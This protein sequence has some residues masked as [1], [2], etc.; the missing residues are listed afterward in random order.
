MLG[1]LAVLLTTG[2]LLACGP[3]AA[4]GPR[5]GTRPIQVVHAG[6]ARALQ[7][8]L[9]YPAEGGARERTTFY[10]SMTWGHAAPYARAASVHGRPLVV[11]AHGWRG[12]RFDLS[13]LGEA[14]ARH[15]YVAAAINMP[16]S[17][18]ESFEDAQAPK[19]WFRAS[20]L[21][22]LI[23]AV[24][25]NATVGPL[26]DTSR[27]AVIGHSAGGSTALVLGGATL[28]PE[29]FAAL[30]PEAAP[31]VAGNWHDGRVAALVALNPGT[32]PAFSPEG[33]SHV[34]VPLLVVSGDGDHVAPEDENAGFYAENVPGAT[35]MRFADV[36]HYSFMPVCS[37]WGRMRHFGACIESHD[38][39]D[40][41]YV[42]AQTLGRVATFLQQTLPLAPDA[43]PVHLCAP[44]PYVTQVTAN[45]P[46]EP[47]HR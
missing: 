43:A 22:R 16:D 10:N 24:G 39:V 31:V 41:G 9:W 1:R 12:T 46:P 18:A 5:V 35:W 19:V 40:R 34:H 44:V 20:M 29:R 36:D 21:S 33:L 15:G 6:L 11:L 14:L 28:D 8:Q 17:D 27:V 4:T 7:G 38:D 37:V 42:H 47:P 3:A 13:W 26:V 30:F 45:T 25:K 32:G 23:D 2:S